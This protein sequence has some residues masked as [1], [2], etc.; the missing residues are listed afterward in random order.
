MTSP[1]VRVVRP[2]DRT[3]PQAGQTAGMTRH[4][5]FAS[6]GRW[7]GIVDVHAGADSGWHHHGDNDSYIYLL[8]GTVRFEFGPAGAESAD[9]ETG[10]F[11]HIPPRVVHRE[12]NRGGDSQAIVLRAGSG[13]VLFNVDGPDA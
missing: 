3:T 5:A 12:L 10:D 4:E 9:A 1:R 11:V 7:A 13:P 8:S 2:A 6:E